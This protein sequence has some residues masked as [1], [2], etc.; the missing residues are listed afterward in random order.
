MFSSGGLVKL[1]VDDEVKVYIDGEVVYNEFTIRGWQWNK[2][3]EFTYSDTARVMAF[4]M[5]NQV[6][7][8]R[9]NS[10]TNILHELCI[11]KWGP[12]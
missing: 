2:V 3:A 7:K 11:D 8:K 6:G 10:N 5:Y 1:R 12:P 4:R 9:E